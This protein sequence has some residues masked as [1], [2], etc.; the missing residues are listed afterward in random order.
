MPLVFA[1]VVVMPL[2]ADWGPLG[3]VKSTVP[4]A[5]LIVPRFKAS[6]PNAPAARTMAELPGFTTRL[7]N[8]WLV[9]VPALS[10]TTRVPPPKTRESPAL[11]SAGGHA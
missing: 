11:A 4:P 9:V 10:W 8:C 2:L 7:L 5:K 1:V 6:E 3:S